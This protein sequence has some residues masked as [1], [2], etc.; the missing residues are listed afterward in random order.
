MHAAVELF[1]AA[2][3]IGVPFAIGLSAEAII[4]AAVIGVA[5]FGLAVSATDTEG[6][7]TL[8]LSTH[9]AYDSAIGFVLIAASIAFGVAGEVGAMAFLLAAGTAQLTLN[10]VTRYSLASG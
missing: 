2:A 3:L 10:S 5:L 6:R 8:P 9:A 7:G 1:T 4:T